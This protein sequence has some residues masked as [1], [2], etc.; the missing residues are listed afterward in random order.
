MCTN[1]RLVQADQQTEWYG[2]THGAATAPTLKMTLRSDVPA[3]LEV[4]VD[5]AA[6]GPAAL[7]PIQRDVILTTTGVLLLRFTVMADVLP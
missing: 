4:T 7:G 6:L 3:R 1:A 2:M 5:P